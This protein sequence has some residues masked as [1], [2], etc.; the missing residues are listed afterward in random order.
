MKATYPL[1]A[2]ATGRGA[3][4]PINVSR[5]DGV[6]VVTGPGLKRRCSAANP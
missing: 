1:A 6:V 2:A 3:Q 4:A 5:F